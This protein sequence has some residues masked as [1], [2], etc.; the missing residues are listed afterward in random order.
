[1]TTDPHTPFPDIDKNAVVEAVITAYREKQPAPFQRGGPAFEQKCRE[2]IAYHLDYLKIAT[3]ANEPE[4]FAEYSRWLRDVL[5]N[6]QVPEGCITTSY[7]LLQNH[8][9]QRHPEQSKTVSAIIEAGINAVN[10]DKHPLVSQPITRA[11][12]LTKNFALMI[13][14]GDRAKSRELYFDQLQQGP[15]L[16]Q[17]NLELLQPSLYEIGRRWQTN[18]LSVA[19]EHMAT[20]ICQSLMAQGFGKVSFA[21]STGKHAVFTAVEGAQHALGIQMVADGFEEAGW[22]CD[23][24]GANTPLTDLITFLDREKPDLL[25]LSAT[26]PVDITRARQMTTQ[27]RVELGNACPLIMVGGLATNTIPR[28]WSLCGADI[29]AINTLEAI[30]ESQ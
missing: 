23:Y 2:D 24:L 3:L 8:F 18:Q 9:T 4:V 5:Q 11:P 26:L 17:T 10:D 21:P 20:A 12:E 29:W 6:R 28:S 19:Q 27:L 7:T 30:K 13:S 22:R 14:Q 1:M 16:A 25:G 15:T